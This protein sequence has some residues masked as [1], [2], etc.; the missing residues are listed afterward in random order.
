MEEN[1]RYSSYWFSSN[2]HWQGAFKAL[3]NKGKLL[4]SHCCRHKCFLVCPRAQHL[5]RFASGT[6][7]SQVAQHGNTTSILCPAR[8]TFFPFCVRDK[9]FPG[10]AAWK[11]NIHFVSR[12]FALPRSIMGNNVSSFPR[13]FTLTNALPRFLVKRTVRYKMATSQHLSVLWFQYASDWLRNNKHSRNK[14]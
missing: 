6:N 1:Y 12:A 3:A 13:A 5:S 9:C 14:S 7:V 2:Y 11:H 4:R 10:C 8:A